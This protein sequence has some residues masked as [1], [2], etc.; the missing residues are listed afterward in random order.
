[1]LLLQVLL[2]KLP[3]TYGYTNTSLYID[4]IAKLVNLFY[5]SPVNSIHCQ[6]QF[7][8]YCWYLM[9]VQANSMYKY[10]Y[11]IACLLLTLH[12]VVITRLWL[13]QA[14][15]VLNTG[16]RVNE[17]NICKTRFILYIFSI[18]VKLLWKDDKH[19]QVMTLKSKKILA[20]SDALWSMELFS[21]CSEGDCSHLYECQYQQILVQI[22]PGWPDR[23][24]YYLVLYTCT[25]FYTTQNKIMSGRSSPGCGY[26]K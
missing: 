11:R 13:Q 5:C 23:G 16:M 15:R 14:C 12:E 26:W 6:I 21:L 25:L 19:C 8:S 10:S 7:M 3:I 4:Y 20:V 9:C 2:Y 24:T 1:M 17:E 18:L 22:S